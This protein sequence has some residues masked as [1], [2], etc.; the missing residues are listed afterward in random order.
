MLNG[1]KVGDRPSTLW[2]CLSR[3]TPAWPVVPGDL[4]TLPAWAAAAGAVR[5]AV[6]L[7]GSRAGPSTAMKEPIPVPIKEK[8]N[9]DQPHLE[10]ARHQDHAERQRQPSRKTR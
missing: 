4:D 8:N 10:H 3:E 2:R 1:L 6:L 7:V 5:F 9:A